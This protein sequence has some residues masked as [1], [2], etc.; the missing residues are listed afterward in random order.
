M[1]LVLHCRAVWGS[2]GHAL[3]PHCLG[4][5]GRDGQRVSHIDVVHASPPAGAVPAPAAPRCANLWAATVPAPGL[6]RRGAALSADSSL[7]GYLGRQLC[8]RTAIR[9]PQHTVAGQNTPA[10][11]FFIAPPAHPCWTA[12]IAPAGLGQGSGGMPRAVAAKRPAARTPT[13]S[14]RAKTRK[15]VGGHGGHGEARAAEGATPSTSSERRS[16]PC[17]RYNAARNVYVIQSRRHGG[18]VGVARTWE[19]GASHLLLSSRSRVKLWPQFVCVLFII[20]RASLG[21]DACM[22]SQPRVWHAKV[23]IMKDRGIP[24]ADDPKPVAAPEQVDAEMRAAASVWRGITWVPSKRSFRVR[25][26]HIFAGYR[27]TLEAALS[28]AMEAYKCKRADMWLGAGDPGNPGD[29]GDAG[30]AGDATDAA[31]PPGSQIVG[32]AVSLLASSPYASTASTAVPSSGDSIPGGA[33]CPVTPPRAEAQQPV[34]VSTDRKRPRLAIPASWSASEQQGTGPQ[35][36]LT[37][38]VN[39]FKDLCQVYGPLLPGDL[40]D[41]IERR[42]RVVPSAA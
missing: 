7:G 29:L 41:F 20:S 35:E 28:L 37:L 10:Y 27:G 19:E 4:A 3:A 39:R 31:D 25:H 15:A 30:D 22:C 33:V 16:I 11:V 32:E 40:Q 1:H 8:M 12:C 9:T 13:P 5:P 2:L 6:P 36:P 14:K 38:K 42:Q 23:K 26:N 21:G 18:Y 17:M 24:V 34:V